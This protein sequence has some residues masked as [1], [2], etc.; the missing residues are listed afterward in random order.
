[1][2]LNYDYELIFGFI[3]EFRRYFNITSNIHEINYRDLLT[4]QILLSKH[5]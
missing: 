1:M 3:H 4:K 2:K 5:Q